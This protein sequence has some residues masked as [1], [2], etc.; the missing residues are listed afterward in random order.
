MDAFLEQAKS[1]AKTA[2]EA[3]RKKIQDT[4]RDLSYSLESTQE[5]AQRILFSV[6]LRWGTFGGYY[7]DSIY[8]LLT[9]TSICN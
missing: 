9:R 7:G 8:T 6:S 4:L 1:L 3:D 2:G 5:S